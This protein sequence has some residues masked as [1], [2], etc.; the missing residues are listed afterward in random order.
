MLRLAV[1]LVGVVDL[2]SALS[3]RDK[4]VCSDVHDCTDRDAL[5][6][7][8]HLCRGFPWYMGGAPITKAS[9]STEQEKYECTTFAASSPSTC[10]YWHTREDGHGELE[11]GFCNCTSLSSRGACESWYCEQ[12]ELKLCGKGAS[13]CGAS[14]LLRDGSTTSSMCCHESCSDTGCVMLYEPR[15][16][17]LEVTQC[18]CVKT[19]PVKSDPSRDVCVGWECDEEGPAGPAYVEHDDV[20]CED[21]SPHGFC[22]RWKLVSDGRKEF[23]VSSCRCNSGGG[24]SSGGATS[25]PRW[26]C[27]ESGMGYFTPNL[28]F[29]ALGVVL[30][31]LFFGVAVVLLLSGGAHD[32]A[33]RVCT[34]TVLLLIAATFEFVTVLFG[35]VVSLLASLAFL[36]AEGASITLCFKWRRPSAASATVKHSSASSAV[37]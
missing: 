4:S 25:C 29:I 12:D 35:G 31:G 18:R 11:V 7:T 34:A 22:T 30:G 17:Q 28:S 23:E 9:W 26:T 37:V 16:P 6:R 14:M 32:R 24:G 10:T 1:I 36:V 21:V 33:C 15:V 19:L 3:C 2:A 27:V 8:G 13:G 20:A 5:F